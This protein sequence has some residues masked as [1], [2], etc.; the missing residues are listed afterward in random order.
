M[1]IGMNCVLMKVKRWN[2]VNNSIISIK[3]LVYEGLTGK[4]E[5]KTKLELRSQC[6]VASSP[7]IVE[8]TETLY[9]LSCI[10]L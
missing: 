7:E 6:V 5:I 3:I 8:K 2:Y 10:I 1:L 4:F 9:S